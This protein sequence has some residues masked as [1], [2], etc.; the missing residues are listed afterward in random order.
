MNT[1]QLS[2]IL[3]TK[4]KSELKSFK[5]IDEKGNQLIN[6]LEM[7]NLFESLLRSSPKSITSFKEIDS[8]SDEIF[9]V[10]QMNLVE[11]DQD[12]S[13]R[14]IN[15]IKFKNHVDTDTR[16]FVEALLIKSKAFKYNE[17]HWSGKKIESE[18]GI[19]RSKLEK[20]KKLLLDSKAIT[21]VN[22]KSFD[23]IKNRTQQV[24]YYKINY[25]NF[26]KFYLS[27]IQEEH[28]EKAKIIFDKYSPNSFKAS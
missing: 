10:N 7:L 25:P 15:F 26:R 5:I 2:A 9:Q 24:N 23:K 18:L 4:D 12:L 3:N 11:Y 1:L 20:N 16:I 14:L 22:K 6:L 17:F 28:I 19:K 13:L 21:I 8:E 27:L